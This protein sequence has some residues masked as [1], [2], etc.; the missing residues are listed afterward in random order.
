MK[1]FLCP[2][3]S[4]VGDESDL[5]RDP[6]WE[7]PVHRKCIVD[8]RTW[9]SYAKRGDGKYGTDSANEGRYDYDV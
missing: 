3:C 9:P 7:N 2:I 5:I 4:R 8:L 1:S 6:R